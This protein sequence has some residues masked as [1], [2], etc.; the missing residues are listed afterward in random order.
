MADLDKG[1]DRGPMQAVTNEKGE[2]KIEIP[3]E[4]RPT[5]MAT[6]TVARAYRVEFNALRNS[7]GVREITGRAAAKSSLPNG[8][9]AKAK[10]FKIGSRTFE[11]HS[12]AAPYD[13]PFTTAR[14]EQVDY[15]R[16]A[17]PSG[18]EGIQPQSFSSLNSELPEE[19]VRLD[20]VSTGGTQ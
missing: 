10:T 8:V 20:G 14:G 13:V 18:L 11:R 2:A 7:G 16:T 12:Y 17:R 15:C 3:A 4:D 9:L 19:T 6:K 1:Y 5:Y